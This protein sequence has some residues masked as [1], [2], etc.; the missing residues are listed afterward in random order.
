MAER[1]ER[2]REIEYCNCQKDSHMIVEIIMDKTDCNRVPD[3]LG[4]L[5]RCI[6]NDIQTIPSIM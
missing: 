3:S 2:I 6:N 5:D 4:F 1:S